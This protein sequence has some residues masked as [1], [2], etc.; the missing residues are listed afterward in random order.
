[1]KIGILT[2]HWATNYGAILQCYALQSFLCE[3][4][5]D[6]E[7]INY[8]PRKYDFLYKYLRRPWLLKYLRKDIIAHNKEK[9]LARFRSE[10]L[11]LTR[12]YVTAKQMSKSCCHYDALISGSD[13]VL[14]ASYTLK[15]EDRPTSAYYLDAF[16][17]SIRIGY[18][19]SFGCE[20]YPQD[21][22]CYASQWINNFTKIGVRE[23]TGLSVVNQMGYSGDVFVVPD[24]T[25]LRGNKLFA[26][27]DIDSPRAQNYI[28]VYVLRKH[29]EINCDSVIYID[30][31]NNP[32]SMERWLGTIMGCE[33]LLTNSY[34]GMIVALLNHIPFVILTDDSNMNDRFYTLLS[35]L[36][37]ED[38]MVNSL[39]DYSCILTRK[40]VWADVDARL[41]DYRKLGYDFL[42]SLQ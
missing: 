28:C 31:Y 5:H 42:M 40:I 18:G 15:G 36:N 29:I 17:N 10:R 8:K 6:V 3:Q 14:N 27:L 32:L 4:G 7:V 23:N 25:I 19:V 38:R 12:R 21:A 2:F 20:I 9:K 35:V 39:Q 33:A 1:M 37:L 11:N 26:N 16:P 13:Q 24:P 30:D 41:S 22:L 34:H